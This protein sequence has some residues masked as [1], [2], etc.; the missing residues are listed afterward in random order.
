MSI[1][2]AIPLLNILVNSDKVVGVQFRN[3][4]DIASCKMTWDLAQKCIIEQNAHNN[5]S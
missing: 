5:F 3:V 1:I 4:I 2:S